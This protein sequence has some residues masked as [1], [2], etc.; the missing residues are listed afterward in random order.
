METPNE[1]PLCLAL[2]CLF[3]KDSY[4]PVFA[5]VITEAGCLQ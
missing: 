3:S 2:L 4:L 1:L 5:M